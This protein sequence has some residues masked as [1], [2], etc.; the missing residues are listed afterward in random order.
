MA[1]D[2]D[3]SWPSIRYSEVLTVEKEV[4]DRNNR[5]DLSIQ[6]ELCGYCLPSF[7]YKLELR[8][9]LTVVLEVERIEIYMTL[10]EVTKLG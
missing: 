10:Q 9:F 5:L 7:M 8:F 2:K 4:C 3:F 6:H 1:I